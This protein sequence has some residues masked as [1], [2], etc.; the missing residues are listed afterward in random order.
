MNPGPLKEVVLCGFANNV[1]RYMCGREEGQRLGERATSR[2]RGTQHD[3]TKLMEMIM[4]F[5][6]LQTS[7]NTKS[8]FSSTRPALLTYILIFKKPQRGLLNVGFLKV[9]IS[10]QATPA[11]GFI[12]N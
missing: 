3:Q 10:A 7:S 6:L 4:H 11:A 1:V 5:L 9:Y 8:H 2:G 12:L